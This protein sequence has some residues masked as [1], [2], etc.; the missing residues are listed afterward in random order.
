MIA[1]LL[2]GCGKESNTISDTGTITIVG[3]DS[4]IYG[5]VTAHGDRLIPT[6]LG[7]QFEIDSLHVE[8][9]ATYVGDSTIVNDW[10]RR[11]NL[12]RIEKVLY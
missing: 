11:V 6:N 8:F 9:E 4:V 12:L 1:L 5:I 7:L 3:T 10:G 2:V